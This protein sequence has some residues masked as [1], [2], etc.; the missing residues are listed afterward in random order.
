MIP[1]RQTIKETHID[2]TEHLYFIIIRMGDTN[3]AST[4]AKVSNQAAT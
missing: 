2:V 4:N 1:T 3:V